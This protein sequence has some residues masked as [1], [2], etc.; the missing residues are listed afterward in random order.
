MIL[1][2]STGY[3]NREQLVTPSKMPS[4]TTTAF[5]YCYPVKYNLYSSQVVSV[6]S[7]ILFYN[8]KP[9]SYVDLLPNY[10]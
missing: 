9:I 3:R 2:N 10:G 5:I 1:L 8:K 4:V 6:L 7:T